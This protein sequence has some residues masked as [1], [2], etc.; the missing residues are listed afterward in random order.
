MVSLCNSSPQVVGKRVQSQINP[1][2]Y[3]K[4]V[5]DSSCPKMKFISQLRAIDIVKTNVYSE[6]INL[7]S[8]YNY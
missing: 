3:F 5:S 6:T 8:T 2:S 1:N 4:I 7:Y